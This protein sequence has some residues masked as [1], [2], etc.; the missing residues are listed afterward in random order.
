MECGNSHVGGE[1]PI[2]KVLLRQVEGTLQLVVIEGDFSGAGAVESSL[3]ERGPCVLQQKAAS[4]IILAHTGHPGIHSTAAVVLHGILPQEEIGK[5][6]N[7]VGC[8]EIWLWGS[9]RRKVGLVG[10]Q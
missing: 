6:P 3:H 2:D 4:Y 9:R 5:Q 7:V 10:T 1:D 8:H